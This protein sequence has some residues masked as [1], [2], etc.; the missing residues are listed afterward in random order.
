MGKV[1]KTK[2]PI[3]RVLKKRKKWLLPVICL[4][5]M[6]LAAAIFYGLMNRS[7]TDTAAT[8]PIEKEPLDFDRLV[9][10]W[11]RPDGGYVIEISIIQQCRRLIRAGGLAE[12]GHCQSRH[13]DAD[14][15]VFEVFQT[16]DF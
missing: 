5:L 11:V 10:N 9:G 15:L 7:S 14:D 1:K 12:K 13:D 8:I 6:G 3:K 4:V 16:V 2:K